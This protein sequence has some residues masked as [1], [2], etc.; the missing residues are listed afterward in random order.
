MNSIDKKALENLKE[1][2][3][4]VFENPEIESSINLK[5]R[6]DRG[7]ILSNPVDYPAMSEK[8]YIQKFRNNLPKLKEYLNK[9]FK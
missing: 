5:R 1:E 8:D 6:G 9:I 3:K 2:H 7:L 4:D